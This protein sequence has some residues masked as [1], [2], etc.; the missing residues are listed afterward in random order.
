MAALSRWVYIRPSPSHNG[1][2]H[3]LLSRLNSRCS[4]CK[5]S[6]LLQWTYWADVRRTGANMVH[7]KCRSSQ[8]GRGPRKKTGADM[9]LQ[10]NDC[11]WTRTS[12]SKTSF[13]S[14]RENMDIRLGSRH[15]RLHLWHVEPTT[16]L[17]C[18]NLGSESGN[19]VGRTKA[20]RWMPSCTKRYDVMLLAKRQPSD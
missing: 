11:I 14:W 5:P 12:L 7:K 18:T 1:H 15:G 9:S 19:S 16:A 17:R 2:V 8:S 6:D 10:S 3:Q 20:L 4:P 13:Q